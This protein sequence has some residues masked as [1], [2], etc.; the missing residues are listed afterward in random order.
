MDVNR[1]SL[2][3]G[4]VAME[5]CWLIPWAVLLGLW[6]EASQ[7]HQLLSP[8]SIAALV[9]LGSLSTQ[10]LGRRAATSRGMRLALVGL[11]LLLALVAVR[12]DQYSAT[13]GLEW[14]GL[15]V[16]ALAV[17]LG[18]V[19]APALAFALGLFLWWRGVRLGTQT[20]SYSDVES[21]FRWGIG[22][23]LTFALVMALST[24]PSLR[25][26]L[27]A[28]T[29]P[30]VVGFFF[31]SLLTLALGRLD[32]LRTRTR[33]LA[34]NS[35]W[36][37][38][39]VVVAGLVVLFALVVAQL[40]SF[41]LLIV[42]TRPLIDLLGQ[43]LLILIYI[44]VIPLAYIVEFLIYLILS[45]VNAD[46]TRQPPQ[47]FQPAEVDNLLQRLLSQ[48]VSPEVLAV[49]KAVGAA[50]VLGVALLAIARVAARW[51]SSNAD[52]DAAGEE[53][54]SLWEPGRLRRALIAWLRALFRRGSP[55]LAGELNLPTGAPSGG[56]MP[57]GASVR[58]LYRQLLGL[59]ESAGARRLPTTTPLEHLPTLQLSLEPEEDIARLTTAYVDVR[60]AD[61]EASVA[62]IAN[63]RDQLERVHPRDADS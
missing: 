23:L 48:S 2:N 6:I 54:D 21:A 22:L 52:A 62:E 15:L 25:S 40:V 20:A 36:L 28:Q 1:L 31:F 59:G 60:Y 4:L 35:Q 8:L 50:L 45:L 46:P 34:V 5:V 63:L 44:I 61:Q 58:E 43:V 18:Q 56:T 24:R 42:A 51:R 16:R 32:S 26:V 41:D 37:G 9:L 11:G 19:S 49:L 29:T 57:A 55:V 27:E 33:A 53:R 12:V 47:P 14:L 38:V 17:M 39:L 7:S 30:F 3:L 10:A 13:S